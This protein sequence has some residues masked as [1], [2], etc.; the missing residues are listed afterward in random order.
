[1]NS[2]IIRKMGFSTYFLIVWD[3][4]NFAPAAMGF[5]CGP[6]PRVAARGRWWPIRSRSRVFVR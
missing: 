1:M 2:S 5:R 6:G 3:F 4:V